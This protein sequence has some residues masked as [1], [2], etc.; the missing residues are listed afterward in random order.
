MDSPS[1]SVSARCRAIS[2]CVE[3]SL[4]GEEDL[5]QDVRID[6]CCQPE[7]ADLGHA[8]RPML[9][10]AAIVSSA[11]IVP[12]SGEHEGFECVGLKADGGGDRAT[13]DEHPPG[14]R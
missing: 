10:I 14:V 8:L 3:C 1:A 13:V 7:S 9:G 5:R 6:I 4:D 11:D 12:G 2:S